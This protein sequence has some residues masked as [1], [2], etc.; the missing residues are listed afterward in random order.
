[1]RSDGPPDAPGTVSLRLQLRRILRRLRS[2]GMRGP[3]MNR[4]PSLRH[5]LPY[6][7]WK[8]SDIWAGAIVLFILSPMMWLILAA[9]FLDWKPFW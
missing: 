7:W 8:N 2:R 5:G 1:M 4:K 9:W 3:T 6:G